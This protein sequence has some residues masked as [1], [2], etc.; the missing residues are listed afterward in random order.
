MLYVQN[1]VFVAGMSGTLGTWDTVQIFLSF[2][3]LIAAI[4]AFI[5]FR[6]RRNSAE[7]SESELLAKAAKQ[8]SSSG[9]PRKP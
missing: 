8:A 7:V 1:Q 5:I 6:S 3:I 4:V 2:G 9:R